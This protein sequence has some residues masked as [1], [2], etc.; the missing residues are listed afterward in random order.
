[1]KP[2]LKEIEAIYPWM[3]TEYYDFDNDKAMVEK[4]RINDRLPVF[5]FL[6]KEGSEFLR[7]QGE[8]DKEELL[9]IID[10]NR[11]Q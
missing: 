5:V 2:R 10:E 4:Y 1:M 7:K 11:D 3:E 8:I 9:K 6:N